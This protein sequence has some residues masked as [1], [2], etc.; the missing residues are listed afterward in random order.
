MAE[1]TR[2]QIAFSRKIALLEYQLLR[3]PE[4]TRPP[5]DLSPESPHHVFPPPHSAVPLTPTPRCF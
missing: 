5:L 3:L 2:E 4:C 1:L